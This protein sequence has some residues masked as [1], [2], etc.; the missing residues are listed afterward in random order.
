MLSL[1]WSLV[2]LKDKIRVLGPGLES[3]V[4]GPCLEIH[5]LKQVT[6]CGVWFSKSQ[7]QLHGA[8]P[9]SRG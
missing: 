9:V 4:L 8:F 3:L 7:W 6:R 2:V 5:V 1:A